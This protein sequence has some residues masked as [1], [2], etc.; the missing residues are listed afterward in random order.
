MFSIAQVKLVKGTVTFKSEKLENVLVYVKDTN[1][2]TVTD[3]YGAYILSVPTDR[4]VLIFKSEGL[5][6]KEVEINNSG[7]IDVELEVYETADITDLSLDEMLKVKVDVSSSKSKTLFTSPSTVTVIDKESIHDYG[8]SS[9]SEALNTVAGFTVY[10][11]YFKRDLPTSRG[12]LQNSYA[13]KILVLI[14]GVPQWN[15]TTGASCV[16]Q[17]NINAVE[18][19]EILKGPA[20]VLYGSNAYIGAVNIVYKETED[21]FAEVYAGIGNGYAYNTTGTYVEKRGE[22]ELFVSASVS[23]EKGLDYEWADRE[24][25]TGIF[26]PYYNMSSLNSSLE[27]KGHTLLFNMY[28][29]SQAFFGAG[30]DWR[31]G[32]GNSNIDDGGL[33]SYNFSNSLNSKIDLTIG[34]YYNWSETDFSRS[35]D[36]S[37]RNRWTGL[38]SNVFARSNFKLQKNLNLELGVEFEYRESGDGFTYVKQN[39]D[40]VSN[41]Q[42]DNK[43]VNEYS[44]FIE[45][46]YDYK[47]LHMYFGSRLTKNEY[48]GY[49]FSTRYSIVGEIN[50]KSSLKLIAGRAYRAPSLFEI[51]VNSPGNIIGNKD[52]QP[53]KSSSIELAYLTSFNKFFVQVLGYYAIY[54]D[55]IRR[56]T[57]NNMDTYINGS[58]F[59]AKGIELEFQYKNSRILNAFINFTYINGDDGDDIGDGD[60]NFKYI[61]K[62]SYTFGITKHYKGFHL[63]AL[64]NGWAETNGPFEKVDHQYSIDA[65]LGYQH[66]IRLTNVRHTLTLKNV[67]NRKTVFPEY[68]QR[69]G[70]LNE[71]PMEFG[72]YRRIFY[73]ILLTF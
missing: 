21:R 54:H 30:P 42:L 45:F 15:A 53:E 72:Y 69:R 10:P 2:F 4:N 29:T 33:I 13:N 28:T 37:L 66:K 44:G 12:V 5:K 14:N 36:D 62:Y 43:S 52:L 11:T 7:V 23:D 60:Y 17:V 55:K 56:A 68:A 34:G 1:I 41:V 57:N 48:F 9:I 47:F 50:N 61:P 3:F 46:D 73:S 16:N 63:A 39:G 71:I 65:S 19:I 67:A 38:R 25:V 27:Y 70:S 8:F 20:S 49:N 6:Q 31:F 51:H 26:K 22:L 40:I 59:S 35:Q 32:V 58:K 64:T 24:G 18:R